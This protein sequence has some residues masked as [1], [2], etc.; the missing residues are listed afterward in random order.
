MNQ[1]DRLLAATFLLLSIGACQNPTNL[2]RTTNP[3]IATPVSMEGT[4]AQA[5]PSDRL[6]ATV[7]STGDGDTLAL[8]INGE[9]VT[10]RPH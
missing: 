6:T 8:N 7:V 4:I 2:S 10:T 1:R 5:R 3:A 9:N